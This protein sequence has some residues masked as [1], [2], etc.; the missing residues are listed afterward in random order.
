MCV[1]NVLQVTVAKAMK[2]SICICV[3]MWFRRQ[4]HHSHARTAVCFLFGSDWQCSFHQSCL[5]MIGFRLN[6]EISKVFVC[7][8]VCVRSK[9]ILH[10]DLIQ[11]S[12]WSY[13][14]LSVTT[15]HCRCLDAWI[16]QQNANDLD[17]K[18]SAATQIYIVG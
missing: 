1:R 12:D 2:A 10:A 8:Y 17:M 3:Y 11:C 4:I 13:L 5:K 6:C 14:N 15:V 9:A 18:T 7:V 16:T